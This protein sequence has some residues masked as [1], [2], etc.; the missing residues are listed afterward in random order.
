MIIELSRNVSSES[1]MQKLFR[2]GVLA[3]GFSVIGKKMGAKRN[4]LLKYTGVA[5]ANYV[6][7]VMM[8]IEAGD[9]MA[10]GAVFGA[11]SRGVMY[12]REKALSDI[13]TY[14]KI[15]KSLERADDVINN[16]YTMNLSVGDVIGK[17]STKL[18]KNN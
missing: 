2:A 1:G 12:F 17:S 6:Y 10:V 8:T 15:Y 4:D 16:I 7:Q 11:A 5:A 18:S 13:N 3:L 9:L 14:T